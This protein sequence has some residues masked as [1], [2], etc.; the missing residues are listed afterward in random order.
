MAFG[1]KDAARTVMMQALAINRE[2]TVSRFMR[3][4]TWRDPKKRGQLRHW[5]VEAGLPS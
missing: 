1:R 3:K 2:L 5:L 4:E